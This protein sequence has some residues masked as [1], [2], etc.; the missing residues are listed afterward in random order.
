MDKLQREQRLMREEIDQLKRQI[1]WIMGAL[2]AL[3]EK[4]GDPTPIAMPERVTPPMS[5]SSRGVPSKS[6]P[7]KPKRCKKRSDKQIWKTSFDPIPMTYSQLYPS[8]IQRGFVTPRGYTNP[9]PNPLP[10]W[11]DPLK[12]CAFHEGAVGHNLEGCYALKAKVQELIEDNILSFKDNVP[13]MQMDPSVQAEDST[14]PQNTTMV[15]IEE[16]V[17]TSEV[18]LEEQLKAIKGKGV[19]SVEKPDSCPTPNIV[20]PPKVKVPDFEEY[21]GAGDP[22]THFMMHS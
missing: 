13:I 2:Q 14:N 15:T 9:S 21:Q 18:A 3:L 10:V 11:H 20:I 12:H 5:G 4:E 8:L 7:L 22:M 19:C 16:S 1:D 6:E 17:T